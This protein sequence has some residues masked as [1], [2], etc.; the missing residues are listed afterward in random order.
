MLRWLTSRGARHAAVLREAQALTPDVWRDILGAYEFL[1][2]LSEAESQAL[3]QRT[4]WI[5]ASKSFHGTHGLT[6]TPAMRHAI[7]AQA[8]LPI[9]GLDTSLYQGW[10]QIVVYPGGFLVP[11]IEVDNAGVVH[12]YTME[13]SG[14]SW[15]GGPVI[16]SWEDIHREDGTN[17]VIHEFAHKL[18]Q[19]AGGAD[20][21]P[22]LRA[23]H[24]LDPQH[25][26]HV[27][28]HA[29]EDFNARLDAV[30]TAIPLHV[31]PESDAAE[32]WYAGL[33]LDPYAAS[34][35]AEF[36]AV[37]SEGFFTDPEPLA[38]AWPDWYDLLARYYR[39]DPRR[40]LAAARAME[41]TIGTAP[42]HRPA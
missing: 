34:D 19:R 42:P 6:V 3:R 36:F 29:F 30:E 4:A 22:E 7:A 27:L 18:D 11:R 31:D 16:L 32:P 17:V 23:H 12:E 8:A 14:E 24:G 2:G 15:E 33:P 13:T 40:R 21:M 5:L 1:R 10:T 28:E 35:L 37:S 38:R 25:W 26:H 41:T 20:G 39:Q 9:L